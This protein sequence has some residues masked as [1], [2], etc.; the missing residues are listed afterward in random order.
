[1]RSLEFWKH[2]YCTY[3][4]SAPK[5]R[6]YRTEGT[7]YHQMCPLEIG[8]TVE[9]YMSSI[10]LE[11]RFYCMEVSPEER[12]YCI[13]VSPEDRF[14]CI[15]VSPEE[16]FHC[17]EVSP[18]DRFHCIEVFPEDRFNLLYRGVPWRQVLLHRGVSW[19]QVSLYVEIFN[20][21]WINNALPLTWTLFEPLRD[22]D[23]NY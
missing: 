3:H 20:I 11:D 5:D 8:F 6:I 19:R 15:E 13:E 22:A 16:R 18:E 14:H 10:S 2:I 9:R 4:Q 12:S 21:R 17:I 1:M 23:D 7:C